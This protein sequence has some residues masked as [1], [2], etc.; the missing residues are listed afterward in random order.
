MTTPQESPRS[1]V[2][3]PGESDAYRAARN[4]LL[5]AQVALRKQIEEVAALRRK[6]PVGGEVGQDYVFEDGAADL[7]DSCETGTV[8][9]S[10]LFQP[11]K[12]TLV[13]YSFMYG[14]E[15]KS[16]CAS[17]TS[18]LDG[19]NGAA[20][21]ILQRVNFAVV[22]KS[23]L[24]RIRAFASGRGWRN[25]RLLSSTTNTYNRDYYGE[26]AE[27]KQLPS[28]NVFQRRDGAIHHFYHSELLFAPSEPG[29]N[30][31]HV[32]LIWPMWNVF[33]FTPEGR[34]ETWYRKLSYS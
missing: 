26:S 3:F 7:A 33:D 8:R 10:E 23:P 22:A 9:M 14:P 19:L 15:M 16:A 31:R 20:P 11:G 32:D 17:C 18:I 34:G 28:L 5:K 2:H 25:L 24:E 30:A 27:G 6:L 4:E 21:H 29:Q 1:S 13:L 12:D